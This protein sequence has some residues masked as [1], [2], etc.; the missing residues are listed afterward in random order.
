M[1]DPSDLTDEQAT[2][3]GSTLGGELRLCP[4][5]VDSFAEWMEKE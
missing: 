1:Y 4:D 3:L 2:I 5:C